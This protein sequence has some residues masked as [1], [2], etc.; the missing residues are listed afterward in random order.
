MRFRV[1]PRDVP[2]EIAARRLG[3]NTADF[4]AALPNLLARGFPKPDPDTGHYDLINR[5]MVRRP[6][7]SPIQQH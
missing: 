6:P 7:R 1:E 3:K 5:Q 4:K 2:I